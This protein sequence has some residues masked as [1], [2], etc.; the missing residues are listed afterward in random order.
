MRRV[1]KEHRIREEVSR[2]RADRDFYLSRVDQAKAIEAMEQ[3]KKRKRNEQQQ[4]E[5]NGNGNDDDNDD[6]ID[7]VES[8]AMTRIKTKGQLNDGNKRDVGGDV[9]QHQQKRDKQQD[10]LNDAISIPKTNRVKREFK[11]RTMKSKQSTELDD[12]FISKLL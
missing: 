2:A 4:D 10:K 1:H 11:Q 5:S 12:D 3:R 7:N 8:K 6:D 9:K